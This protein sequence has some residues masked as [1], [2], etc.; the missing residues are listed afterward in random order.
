MLLDVVDAHAPFVGQVLRDE[1]ITRGLDDPEARLLVEWL[2]QAGEALAAW[3]DT[4]LAAAEFRALL[5]R[6]RGLKRFV[7]LW[8]HDRDHGAAAQLA[9]AE[10][11]LWPLPRPEELDP[12]HIMERVLACETL[13]EECAG[14]E[15]P[16]RAA[17]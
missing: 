16:L 11:F 15:P 13:D 17:A 3:Q 8:C 9:Q 14:E 10:G 5:R 6:C 2:A 12:C 4:R 1:G 7:I